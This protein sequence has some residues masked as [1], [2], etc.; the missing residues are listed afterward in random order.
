MNAMAVAERNNILRIFKPWSVT[1]YSRDYH[2]DSR[3]QC[4]EA[5]CPQAF[6]DASRRRKIQ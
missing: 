4:A 5:F 6:H 2:C 3:I 1:T